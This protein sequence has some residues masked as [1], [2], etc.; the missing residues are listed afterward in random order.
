MTTMMNTYIISSWREKQQEADDGMRDGVGWL[1][2][3]WGVT[4]YFIYI[5][6]FLLQAVSGGVGD[7][8]DLLRGMENQ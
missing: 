2:G 3:T 4:L 6:N 7:C 1:G 8:P 5:S